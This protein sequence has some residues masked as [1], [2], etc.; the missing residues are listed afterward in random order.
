M[1]DELRGIFLDFDG[2]IA[3]TERFGQRA[4]YNRAFSELGLDWGWDEQLY[5]D[6]L[7]V[8]GGKER[9][10]YY[11]ERY[12]PESLD[13]SISSGLIEQIHRLKI[14]HFANVAPTIP[15]RP[16]VL[17]LVQEAH[18]AGISI[19][20]ATTASSAGVDA[21]LQQSATLPAMVDLIAANEAVDRKK[22]APDV[23]RWAL[24]R[25]DL[26]ASSCIAIEDSNVGL[27][28]A[29]AADLPTVITVSDYTAD[30]DFSGAS[31]VLSSLGEPDEPAL[32][33]HGASPQDGFVDLAFLRMIRRLG[34]RAR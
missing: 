16:G 18:D 11:L 13:R 15:L 22:P 17:R 10:R 21:L 5:A 8:A 30:D 6:L 3:E 33:L 26:P 1:T 14:R 2:T 34:M 24:D 9:L 12:R 31:A 23:Y 32:S 20:V 27:R 4:A 29:L 28:A 7:S 19:A 25:L